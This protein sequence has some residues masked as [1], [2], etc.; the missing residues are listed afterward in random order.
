[1]TLQIEHSE[2]Q[3]QFFALIEGEKALLDYDFTHDEHVLE[4]KHTYVPPK[5]RGQK[6]AEKIVKFALDYAR[7][8]NYK[9]IPTCPYVQRFL[10][11]FPEYKLLV[12]YLGEPERNK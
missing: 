7:D 12:A 6:I 1:M 10:E 4:Y 3:K 8:H 9:I 5:L 2:I 11:R